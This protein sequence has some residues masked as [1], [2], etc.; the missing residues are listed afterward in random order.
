MLSTKEYLILPGKS[1]EDEYYLPLWMHF[2]D[3]AG[4]MGYLYEHR[5][6]E[7]IVSACDLPRD[8]LKKVSIF[9]AMTHDIG[10]C[11]PLFTSRILCHLPAVSSE[12]EKD[13]LSI[14]PLS[15][16]LYAGKSLHARAGEAILAESGCPD[17]ICSVVGAH[18]GKPTSQE[19]IL[20]DPIEIYPDNF[21]AKQKASWVEMQQIVLTNALQRAGYSSVSELP[22]LTNCAQMLLCGLLIEADWIASNQTYFPLIRADEVASDSLYPGRI[23]RALAELSMPEVWQAGKTW[24]DAGD[25]FE[26][27][28]GF[29]PNSMQKR[30]A[31]I[32]M[33]MPEPGLMIIEAQ[34]GTGKTEAAI[35]A[36]EI[37]STEFGCGGVFFGLPTQATSNG[38]F[39]RF[40]DWAVRA[41]KDSIHTIRLVHGMAELND[42]YQRFFR[43]E[44]KTDD[45]G[46]SGLVAHTW[47]SGKKQALL[48]DFVVGTVD[49]AL[50]A[51][52]SQRH[53]MLR[54]LGLA[55]KVVVIDECHTYDAY[56]SRYLER[57]LRW[58]GAYHVPVIL[59]SATLPAEKKAAM[60]RAYTGNK[61][62]SLPDMEGY[63]MITWTEHDT[64]HVY[65]ENPSVALAIQIHRIS[66]DDLEKQ[67]RDK[68]RDGGCAGVIVN[69]VKR[70]QAIGTALQQ[71]FPD[72]KVLVYHAQ[73][74]AEDRIRREKEL[75]G[76]IGKASTPK[77]RDN[78]IIVGTQVLEQSLDI[79]FDYLISDLCPM[80]LLL[81]RIGRLRRHKRRRPEP[82]SVPT[83]DVLG[84]G[85]SFESGAQKIYGRW[86]LRQTQQLL[87]EI[88]RL[89]TDIPSLVNRTYAEPRLEE[90]DA[91]YEKF[92][93]DSD[94]EKAKAGTCLLGEP[95]NSRRETGNSIVGMLDYSLDNEK[96]AEASVRDGQQS[97]DVLVMRKTEDGHFAFLPWV[98]EKE[99]RGDVV[100]SS[101][102]GRQIA[103]QRLRLPFVFCTG[104]HLDETVDALE[105]ENKEYLSAW[106]DSPWLRGELVLILDQNAEK[107]LNGYRLKYEKDLGLTYE[108]SDN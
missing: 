32:A 39:P 9:L 100:P 20:K 42:D 73:F 61:K 35:A 50:M 28:F 57:M 5:I 87:P 33:N 98:S 40:S 108:R 25:L 75:T 48:A 37:M 79:D 43:G 97:V 94:K 83:C 12:L 54:H 63:P 60:L 84:T 62:L 106:Q 24:L 17:G 71:R 52:L 23:A 30:A 82:M 38:I 101:E 95:K 29:K 58:L 11:T 67:L 96:K 8:E 10:K 78:L 99:L 21:F 104:K 88:I 22:V 2:E 80:D 89:P 103:L 56:M 55:G 74:L 3:T 16:F 93:N 41:S 72:K 13:G 34:M 31:E 69:T 76:L 6:T 4:V 70:A 27:R 65:A 102:D 105:R 18:H 64:A 36:A 77:S 59:L 15:Y 86:L 107:E 26:S 81:Q 49:N 66:E 46:D 45:D 68:L 1:G 44:G 14:L 7:S 92:K 91:D 19:D 47:F 90:A 85:E 53:V 51:A